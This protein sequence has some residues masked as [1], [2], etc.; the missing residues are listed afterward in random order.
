LIMRWGVT[1]RWTATLLDDRMNLSKT[2]TIKWQWL[3]N[4]R[5]LGACKSPGHN[6]NGLQHG[7]RANGPK[8]GDTAPCQILDAHLYWWFLS[9][10]KE[11]WGGTGAI[12]SSM[13][14]WS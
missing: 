14:L 5:E 2:Q 3:L 9:T 10:Q 7:T 12:G 1:N 13:K 8:D 6:P 4:K 11:F